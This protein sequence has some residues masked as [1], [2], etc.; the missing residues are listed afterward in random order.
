MLQVIKIIKHIISICKRFAVIIVISCLDGPR[1]IVY[2]DGE[3]H[4]L[5]P[6]QS[7]VEMHRRYV[8]QY[9]T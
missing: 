7:G 2:I 4:R 1:K 5:V 8:V 9:Q 3:Y 6:L